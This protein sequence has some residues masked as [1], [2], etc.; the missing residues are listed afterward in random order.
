[1]LNHLAEIVCLPDGQRAQIGGEELRDTEDP[2]NVQHFVCS[3]RLD[4]GIPTWHYEAGGCTIE[5][6]VLLLHGQNT[7]LCELQFA[8]GTG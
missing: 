2:S 6:R 1:M 5:K 3:F 8:F 4:D 7:V